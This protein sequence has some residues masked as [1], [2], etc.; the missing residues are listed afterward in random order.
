MQLVHWQVVVNMVELLGW[1]MEV[2]LGGT[3]MSVFRIGDA[4]EL[5]TSVTLN[6]IAGD[7]RPTKGLFLQMLW[8]RYSYAVAGREHAKEDTAC[9][10]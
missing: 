8:P 4:K 1:N 9:H 10:P 6:L 7:G 2:A 3:F 5:G